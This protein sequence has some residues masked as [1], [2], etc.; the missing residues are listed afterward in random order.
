MRSFCFEVSVSA[1][2]EGSCIKSSVRV[3]IKV[4]ILRISNNY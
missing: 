1:G 2:R 3:E 4:E